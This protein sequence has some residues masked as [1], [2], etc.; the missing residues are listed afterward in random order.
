MGMRYKWVHSLL[1]LQI[2]NQGV[3]V[4]LWPKVKNSLVIV[5]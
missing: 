3:E 4:T 2:E 5:G 1:E